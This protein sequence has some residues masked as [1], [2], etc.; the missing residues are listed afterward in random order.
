MHIIH[1]QI[2]VFTPPPP[3]LMLGLFL[4][5]CSCQILQVEC[6]DTVCSAGFSSPQAY[7]VQ[8][9]TAC[10]SCKELET[11]STTPSGLKPAKVTTGE[12][13]ANKASKAGQSSPLVSTF[14]GVHERY[15]DCEKKC[16]VM[17]CPVNDVFLVWTVLMIAMRVPRIAITQTRW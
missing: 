17:Y 9:D 11:A 14:T 7:G 2:H 12:G 3:P 15:V 13:S 10:S 6:E 4:D 1:I 5:S 16:S 8:R